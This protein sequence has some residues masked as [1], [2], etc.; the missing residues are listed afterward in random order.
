MVQIARVRRQRRGQRLIQTRPPQPAMGRRCAATQPSVDAAERVE[1]LAA[2]ERQGQGADPGRG[3]HPQIPVV[4]RRLDHQDRA[5]HE[6]GRDHAQVHQPGHDQDPGRAQVVGPER[7]PH[8]EREA[9]LAELERQQIVEHQQPRR[10]HVHRPGPRRRASGQRQRRRPAP[11]PG[12]QH[13]CDLRASRSNRALWASS[14]GRAARADRHL[15]SHPHPRHS[16]AAGSR[17]HKLETRMGVSPVWQT[18]Q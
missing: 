8:H 12:R 16:R 6:H 17:K 15:Q 4:D 5:E 10:D 9:D 3:Q 18:M 11:M 2:E 13:A 14:S 7:P 1:Q